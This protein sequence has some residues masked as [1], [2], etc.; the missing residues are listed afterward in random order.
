VIV[1]VLLAEF[2][3]T[4]VLE[5]VTVFVIVAFLAVTVTLIPALSAA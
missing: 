2:D 4:V 1:A 5:T 3:S